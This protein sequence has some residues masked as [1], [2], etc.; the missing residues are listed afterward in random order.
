[1][2][3]NITYEILKSELWR[4]K[5]LRRP[6]YD[7]YLKDKNGEF[8]KALEAYDKHINKIKSFVLKKKKTT[9]FISFTESLNV[10]N[11]LS[12]P[13]LRVLTFFVTVMDNDNVVN[14][15]NYRN[16]GDYSDVIFVHIPK[17]IKNLIEHNAIK[18]MII[19]NNAR[20]YMINPTLFL[21]EDSDDI[22]RLMKKFEEFDVC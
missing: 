21:K 11:K 20:K 2:T 22:F 10:L 3:K 13:A 14:G 18:V 17:A 15:Y 4:I 6:N 19:D 5:T 1:M 7:L 9:R 8:V 16:I 12:S